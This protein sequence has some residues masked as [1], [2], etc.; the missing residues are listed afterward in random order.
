[1]ENKFVPLQKG[2]AYHGNRMLAHVKDDMRDIVEHGFDTVVHMFSHNDWDRH[3]SIMKEIFDITK[4]YGLDV[5]VDN[6]GLGGPP[7]DKSHF[8]AYYP[9]S[10]QIYSN[11]EMDPVHACYNSPDFVQFTRDWIDVVGEAGGDKIFWD[12]PHLMD[13]EDKNG[14]GRKF[15]C[16]CD[17]C[18]RLFEERYG[19]PMPKE[20]TPE[21]EEFRTWS[22]VN[23]FDNA[24][25]Y[26]KS[27]G[28]Q[29]IICIMLGTSGMSLDY[30]EKICSVPALDNIGSDPYWVNTTSGYQD[31]YEF[32]Y[33]GAKRNVDVCAQFHKDHNI[34]IQGYNNP[35][36]KEEDII[37]AADAIYDAGGRN[38]FVWGY[39]GSD[40][41]DYRSVNP[42]R[43]WHKVGE[44]MHRLSERERDARRD[45]ARKAMGLK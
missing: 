37:A 3:K 32:V 42:D 45:A 7:G 23:Y 18:R 5:W 28:M 36:G 26:A 14:G 2:V 11:G 30:I 4:S 17:H 15:T 31:V 34:W 35:S 29:N 12:E 41:N 20:L 27:H 33:Q 16:C 25:G 24:S 21:V 38:I 44:A 1:M 19:K 40:A 22:I 43:A 8:L 6:W 39:R 10:H 9:G 13:V